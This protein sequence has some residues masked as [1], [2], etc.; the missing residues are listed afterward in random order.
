MDAGAGQTVVAVVVWPDASTRRQATRCIDSII[1]GGCGGAARGPRA[2]GAAARARGGGAAAAR[3]GR[4]A[5]AAPP[6]GPRS[7]EYSIG[8]FPY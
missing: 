1:A 6:R 4:R 8:R 7:Y 5:A 3:A 2:R